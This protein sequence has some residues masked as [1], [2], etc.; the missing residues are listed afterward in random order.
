MSCVR[1]CIGVIDITRTG[2]IQ[3]RE[4]VLPFLVAQVHHAVPSED[5]SVATVPR[6]HNAV[7][8]IYA[9][10]NRLQDVPRRTDAHQVTGF[11]LREDIVANLDHVI[12]HFGRLAYRQTAY[13]IP[14]S[15]KVAQTLAGFLPQ[16]AVRTALHDREEVLLIAV[17]IFR[18]IEAC[19]TAVEP[20][21]RAVHR[22]LGVFLVRRAGTALIERHHDVCADL[23]LDIHYVL[24]RE[25][26]L[27]AVDMTAEPYALFVHLADIGQRK[28]LKTAAVRQD[29]S[30]PSFESVQAACLT[31]DLRTR[32]QEQMIRVA[33]DDLRLDIVL[34]FLTLNALNRPYCSDRHKDGRQDIAVVGM[35]HSRS[36][37]HALPLAM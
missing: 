24:R 27:A 13:G 19:Y 12:H 35:Y 36:R 34:Q 25:E 9:A 23:P 3:L 33:Q 2:W 1:A 37:P 4:V 20:A 21:V 15:V 14:V 16:V 32:A 31:Q 28:H 30:F 8:H 26:Q 11:V 5:H 6:R 29:R 10:F 7:E 17:Q 18:A 22:V